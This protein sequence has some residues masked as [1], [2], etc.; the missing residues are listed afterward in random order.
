[1]SAWESRVWKSA[2]LAGFAAFGAPAILS[3]PAGAQTTQAESDVVYIEADEFINEQDAGRVIARGDVQAR[4][5]GR[6]LQADEV[7][8]YPDLGRVTATGGVTILEADGSVSHAETV[9]LA[10]DLSRGVATEFATRLPQDGKIG[11]SYILRSSET[12]AELG[13]AFYTV[14]DAC[15][16]NGRAKRPT[17]RLK[18]R[19]VVQDQEKEMIYYRDAVLEIKGVPVLYSPFFA[20]A[21]PTVGRKSGFLLPTFG[22]SNKTGTFYEQ[23]YF[24]AISEHQDLTFNT[25]IMTSANPLVGF[26]HR[27][28][29]FSGGTTFEGSLTYERLFD[30][31][32]DKFDDTEVRG[33]IF[34]EGAFRVTDDW[35]WGFG[36]ER[37]TDDLYFRRYDIDGEDRARGLYRRG[38]K[39]LLSQVY[40]TGQDDN[41]YASVA[42]LNFQGLRATD[43]DGLIPIVAPLA[44]LRRSYDENVM[45]GRIEAR[46][47]SAVLERQDG[48]DS[49]RLT[50]EAD[51]N[52]PTVFKNG[53]VATPFALVRGDL[54]SLQDQP[55]LSGFEDVDSVTRLLGYVGA[56]VRYPLAKRQGP[57]DIILEPRAMIVLSPDD[58][59]DPVPIEDADTFDIDEANI[60]EPDR[61]PGYDIWE[62]GS[63]A[64][65]GGQA[66]ARWGDKGGEASLFVAQ[67]YRTEDFP[68][69]GSASGLDGTTSDWVGA[70]SFSLDPRNGVRARF[71]IDDE[72]YDVERLDV[73]A[74][75]AWGPAV[76][77]GRYLRFE[78]SLLSGRPKEEASVRAGVEVTR[79]W[80]VYYIANR[81][82]ETDETRVASLGLIFQDEC[83]RL[84]IVYKQERTED[85]AVGSGDSIRFQFTL[86]TLGSVR[87]N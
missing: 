54:Y 39:R 34:G 30:E 55:L 76:V 82:L 28:R 46:A 84:E 3:A 42:A 66:T 17:W 48:A 32:G 63:R 16:A 87:G 73:D 59:A 49:R 44:E 6:T 37:V 71:R 64:T 57:I 31:N 65:L 19:Q 75:A 10:S 15:D 60:F 27:Y 45:G 2:L 40:A 83:S 18:A 70:A 33:H 77:G 78:E 61:S 9:D 29:F 23:P 50:L 12:Y 81:D 62:D 47:S 74:R 7:V 22:E 43:D 53:V 69:F 11:A 24:W 72:D 5:D 52:R 67:S 21:D 14:C 13:D 26:Q 68:A 1:M 4:Y 58:P 56:D 79:N 25:R 41:Y 51:W 38:S 8:Y 86:A 20:H 85:R 80:G 35:L 36:V